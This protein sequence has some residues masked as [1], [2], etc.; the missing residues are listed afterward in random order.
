MFEILE[1]ENLPQGYL[2]TDSNGGMLNPDVLS[3]DFSQ[4]MSELSI[5]HDLYHLRHT[6][7]TRLHTKGIDDKIVALWMGHSSEKVTQ[8]Y[9]I[10]ATPDMIAEAL[11]KL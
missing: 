8:E 6:Y 10:H 2:V 3:N 11:T 9:Y 4:I 1:K 7:G 5:N